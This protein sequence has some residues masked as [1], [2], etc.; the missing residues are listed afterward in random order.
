MGVSLFFVNLATNDVVDESAKDR[1]V[2]A[3]NI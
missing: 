2:R 1:L 3:L